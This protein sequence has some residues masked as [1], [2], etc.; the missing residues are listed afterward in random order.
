MFDNT[1]KRRASFGGHGRKTRRVGRWTE[2]EHERFLDALRQ[3]GKDWHMIAR[4]VGTRHVTNI[5]AHAQK[6]LLKLVKVVENPA[7]HKS[8]EVETSKIF[9][10]LL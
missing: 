8:D 1:G 9:Y 10:D 2:E 7:D 6:F 4:Q 5:R 3:Y